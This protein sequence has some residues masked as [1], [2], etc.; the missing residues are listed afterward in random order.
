[1]KADKYAQKEKYIITVV[2]HLDE[3]QNVCTYMHECAHT[4]TRVHTHI[5]TCMCVHTH[6]HTCTRVHTHARYVA[7]HM[8]GYTYEYI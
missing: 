3:L 1:M 7:A 4:C 6:I 2:P 5:H 8:R